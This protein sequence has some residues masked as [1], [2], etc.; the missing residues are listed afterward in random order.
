MVEITFKSIGHGVSEA[1]QTAIGQ[2]AVNFSLLEN[3]FASLAIRL[4]DVDKDR[5][6]RGLVGLVKGSAARQYHLSIS[7][8]R[9]PPIPNTATKSGSTRMSPA[10]PSNISSIISRIYDRMGPTST[11]FLRSLSRPKNDQAYQW[12]HPIHYPQVR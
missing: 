6:Y 2:V 3:F 7:L 11:C 5:G 4:M 10:R 1:H 9:D 12:D 8:S